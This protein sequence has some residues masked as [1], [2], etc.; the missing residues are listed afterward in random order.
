MRSISSSSEWRSPSGVV[1]WMS[2]S[3]SRTPY[4]NAA[5]RLPP[6]EKVTTT[7]NLS[8]LASTP[9][10]STGAVRGTT[11]ASGVSR[12]GM[13]PQPVTVRAM[14]ATSARVRAQPA[15]FMHRSIRC[16]S[17]GRCRH[18]IQVGS[19]DFHEDAGTRVRETELPVQAVC[20][21]RAE[22]GAARAGACGMGH[23][24]A[25]AQLSETV[26]AVFLE[27]VHVAEVG[28]RGVVGDHARQSDLAPARLLVQ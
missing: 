12:V 27:H 8:E 10:A 15:G 3:A 4:E 17:S 11:W 1:T 19:Y 28:E 24:R 25:H 16:E 18:S 14:V 13:L 20:I 2:R 6:P 5:A 26:P 9:G 23:D 7:N 21:A 22:H